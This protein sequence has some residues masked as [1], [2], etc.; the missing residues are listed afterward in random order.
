MMIESMGWTGRNAYSHT[1]TEVYGFFYFPNYI[2][3]AYYQKVFDI[4]VILPLSG[5]PNGVTG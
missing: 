4:A 2:V 5:I 3:I 1:S